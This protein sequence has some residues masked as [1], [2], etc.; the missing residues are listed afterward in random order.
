MAIPSQLRQSLTLTTQNPYEL[1]RLA[2]ELETR[3]RSYPKSAGTEDLHSDVP[4]LP[5]YIPLSHENPYL[6]GETFN[7][8]AFLQSR[9]YTSLPD[10]RS[11]LREYLVQLKEELVRLINDDYEA[12][13][14]LSTDLRDEG[15]RLEA[16]KRPLNGIRSQI[17]VSQYSSILDQCLFNQGSGLKTRPRGDPTQCAGEVKEALGPSRRESEHIHGG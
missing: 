10:L 1:E 11:E 9:S 14:S 7:I 8:E 17:L 3:E 4:T 15:A 2:E 12:F 5:A 16:L 13:I 6:T